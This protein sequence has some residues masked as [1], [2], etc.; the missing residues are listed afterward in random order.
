MDT[1]TWQTVING[2]LLFLFNAWG[3]C[4]QISFLKYCCCSSC[5]GKIVYSPYTQTRRW[6]IYTASNNWPK[7]VHIT[8]QS[9]PLK[10]MLLCKRWR[11]FFCLLRLHL[12]TFPI[13]SHPRSKWAH[14]T[15]FTTASL[16]IF[17]ECPSPD[18]GSSAWVL[19]FMRRRT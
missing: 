5:R 11:V 10:I 8:F 1:W 19:V 17:F 6:G 16:S 12:L 9:L 18:E 2:W 15:T 14:L 13:L 3:T 7:G 4:A